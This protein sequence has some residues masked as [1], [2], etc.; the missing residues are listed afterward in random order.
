M[1]FEEFFLGQK[2]RSSEFNAAE[3]RIIGFSKVYDNIPLHTDP[4]YAKTT[5]FKKLISSGFMTFLDAWKEFIEQNAF[6][7]ELIAGKSAS[8]EWFA[9]VFADD[10]LVSDCTVTK[11]TQRNA[12]NGIVEVTICVYK[13]GETNCLMKATVETVV[14][15]K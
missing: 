6:G 2:F 8:M 13:K 1:Y 11:L 15:R 7:D 4:E 5:R 14:K 9:P 12:H 3:K 10:I